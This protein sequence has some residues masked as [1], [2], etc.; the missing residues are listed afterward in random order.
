MSAEREHEPRFSNYEIR[1]FA[2]ETMREQTIFG[3]DSGAYERFIAALMGLRDR[4][5]GKWWSDSLEGVWHDS[6]PW[7]EKTFPRSTP[8]SIANHILSEAKE[9]V[10]NPYDPA[11]AADIALLLGHL[12]YKLKITLAL[13]AARKFALNKERVWGQPNSEGF[14][15]HVRDEPSRNYIKLGKNGLPIGVGRTGDETQEEVDPQPKE[16]PTIEVDAVWDERCIEVEKGVP[17]GRSGTI[18]FYK[19]GSRQFAKEPVWDDEPQAS[20]V[21]PMQQSNGSRPRS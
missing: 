11:E 17:T 12:Q 5:E 16:K 14:V 8:Q 2:L 21:R 3:V 7:S 10:S 13:E 6:V 4:I 20:E 18:V 19:I 15:E 9:L 1:A